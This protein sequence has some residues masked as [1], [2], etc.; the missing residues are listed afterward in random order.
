MNHPA[1]IASEDTLGLVKRCA[2]GDEAAYNQLF[3]MI[4]QISE[5]A[6]ISSLRVVVTAPCRPPCWSM[7]PI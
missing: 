6:R 4:Y 2:G 7:K 1:E 3:E 5:G